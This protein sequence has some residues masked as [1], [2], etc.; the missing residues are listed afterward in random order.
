MTVTALKVLS[1]EDIT[2][3]QDV[4]QRFLLSRNFTQDSSNEKEITGVNR[5]FE[6]QMNL[7]ETG[8]DISCVNRYTYD[9]HQEY[10]AY[11]E[12]IATELF[13]LVGR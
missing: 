5:D 6:F 4:V 11:S 1:A 8:I 9:V 12:N 2:F 7:T 10:I 3:Y 13:T